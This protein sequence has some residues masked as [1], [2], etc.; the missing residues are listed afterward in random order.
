MESREFMEPREFLPGGFPRTAW[1]PPGGGMAQ[2]LRNS[3]PTPIQTLALNA[4][5][6]YS[7]ASPVQALDGGSSKD[8]K[9]H[10]GLD[11]TCSDDDDDAASNST[12]VSSRRHSLGC[13][14]SGTESSSSSPREQSSTGA[15]RNS[16]R[17]S[18]PAPTRSI[19]GVVE[20]VGEECDGARSVVVAPTR[21]GSLAA[22]KLPA[23][24]KSEEQ[25]ARRLE[26]RRIA[27]MIGDAA[28][29][30]YAAIRAAFAA[31]DITS[32]GWT[33]Q[34]G[35]T[36]VLDQFGLPESVAARLVLL[37]DTEGEGRANYP[38]FLAQFGP[39]MAHPTKDSDHV[40][41]PRE[42][43]RWR[44]TPG[45]A[46]PRKGPLPPPNRHTW[47]LTPSVDGQRW[48]FA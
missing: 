22:R 19:P 44:L 11:G 25:E 23:A 15:S 30:D 43:D 10:K 29:F 42:N 9:T 35:V 14:S 37:L 13:Q 39:L 20:E 31:T 5:R 1:G 4:H 36:M 16:S 21:S 33:T 17:G 26:L 47:R 45:V 41:V 34:L 38:R 28:E 6:I 7:R 18:S 40:G 12:R 8:A 32:C 3:L 27:L 46:H 2:R 48:S 24:S